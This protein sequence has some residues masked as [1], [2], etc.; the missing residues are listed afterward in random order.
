MA[1]RYLG[2]EM[3]IVGPGLRTGM[4]IRMDNPREVG[5][6]RLV[7]SVA[8][9]DRM[10]GGCI[11]VDFGTAITYDVV[12]DAGEYL[13]GIITPGAEISIDA[14]YQRAAKLA[15][16]RTGR[17]ARAD[18][19]VDGRGD[20][21]GHRVRVRRTGRGDRRPP[22]GGAWR[23]DPGRRH[24]R[25]VGCA[26]ADGACPDRRRR[27][28]ADAHRAAPH[29]GAQR[30]RRGR[31]RYTLTAPAGTGT[32]GVRATLPA[33]ISTIR[34]VRDSGSCS[35]QLDV[36]VQQRSD[37]GEHRRVVELF[38][39]IAGQA[40]ERDH[41]G[42]AAV[43]VAAQRQ[44]RAQQRERRHSVEQHVAGAF[45]LADRRAGGDE[46]LTVGDPQ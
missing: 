32:S 44:D 35:R 28:E 7:N 39:N 42:A 13:G 40:G 5:A 9:Y 2:H 8:A 27:P 15:Q 45:A 46:L 6:D 19:Q 25:A 1:G 16:G 4:P 20:P 31:G 30:R 11:V 26:G 24:R 14:L 41:L 18:R 12:S 36:A 38:G 10:G 34:G 3:L 33:S 23:G 43:L 17:A 29:L 22:A 37:R 21:L